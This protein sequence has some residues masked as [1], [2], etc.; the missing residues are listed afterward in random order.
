MRHTDPIEA[1]A[2]AEAAASLRQL[3]ERSREVFKRIVEPI[4][5]LVSRS[6]RATSPVPC[7]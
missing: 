6:A 3:N 7:P 4:S 1:R 5:P 2:A